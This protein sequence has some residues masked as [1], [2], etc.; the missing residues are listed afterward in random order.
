[1]PEIDPLSAYKYRD[2]YPPKWVPTLCAVGWPKEGIAQAVSVSGPDK[3]FIF[4]IEKP[5]PYPEPP[6]SRLLQ[7]MQAVA[8]FLSARDANA[9][10]VSSQELLGAVTGRFQA[11]KADVAWAVFT[12][13]NKAL[14]EVGPPANWSIQTSL[15]GRESWPDRF[16][17]TM[18]FGIELTFEEASVLAN[19]HLSIWRRH[20]DAAEVPLG[21]TPEALSR[22][23]HLFPEDI[24]HFAKIREVSPTDVADVLS[25]N[26]RL[27][28]LENDI[29]K[30]LE[31][32]LGV[33]FHKED[34]G[35]EEN[36][37]FTANVF[38]GNERVQTAFLLK[39]RAEK[40]GELQIA[41]CGTNGDQIVRLF[42]SPAELFVIQYVG[43]V[44]EAVI[45]DVKS[46]VELRRHQGRRGW[47]CIIDGQDTARLL[48]AYE[49]L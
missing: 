4:R 9:G 42:Q 2:Q 16:S 31:E 6:A 23:I 36:D 3:L 5:P 34:W 47:F 33:P 45:K 46:K 40:A 24:G 41:N 13:A 25:G 29:Q 15:H 7:A 48:R 11:N 49:K 14:L 8:D 20:N 26:G 19:S 37:L 38:I 43:R 10:P 12:L 35:G 1:M 21:S 18:I 32:I 28:R 44:S 27:D 22:R 39:G 17:R 30:A